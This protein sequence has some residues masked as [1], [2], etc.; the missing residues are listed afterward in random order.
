MEVDFTFYF[1]VIKKCKE[2]DMA[3]H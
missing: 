3:Y 1:N 2:M